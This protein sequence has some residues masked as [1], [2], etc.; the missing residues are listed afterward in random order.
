[1]PKFTVGRR[2]FLISGL[3]AGAAVASGVCNP[4]LSAPPEMKG[5]KPLN[6]H[7]TAPNR[8][9]DAG[10]VRYAY[11]RF[12]KPGGVPI[13]L[14][15]HF[16]GTMDWWDP[17][18]T[19]GLAA[20]REVIIFDNRG[21]GLTSGQTPSRI[22]MMADDV[23]A[24]M[25]GLKLGQIDLLAFS[26]GGMIGQEL[27]L[28]YPSAVR[29]L[30]LSG[31]GPRGGSGMADPKPNINKA[32]TEAGSDRKQ[33]RP[34]LFF[35]QTENGKKAAN[36]FM[37]RTAERTEG[38]DLESSM[39][40][41]QAQSE[42]LGEFG[43]TASRASYMARLRGLKQPTLITNG[44]NDIMVDTANSYDLVQTIPRAELII[45]PDSGHGALF[46]YAD[47]YVQH[48]NLFLNRADI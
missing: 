40:T 32:L 48:L 26:I 19:D 20:T 4:A 37:A 42:A 17:A 46:Q 21:V 11:R 34:Y 35:S 12:G 8:F 3:V 15:H 29:K 24:F 43:A 28:R 41:M 23:H 45:Y 6:T 13:L 44:N 25:Q 31:T 47:L 18:L 38:L 7:N 10:G 36:A 16:I 14:L 22:N 30:I 5:S 33:A 1:M 27:T 9:I 2:D 39:Q